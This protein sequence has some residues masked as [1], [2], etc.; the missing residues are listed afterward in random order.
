M[1]MEMERDE[2]TETTVERL[3]AAAGLLEQAVE[4]LGAA[5]ER[6]CAGC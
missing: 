5:T 3:A 1:E 2:L 4:R 6:V